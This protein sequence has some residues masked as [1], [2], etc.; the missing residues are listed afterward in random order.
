MNFKDMVMEAMAS[1]AYSTGNTDLSAMAD[2]A[3][4]VFF[5]RLLKPDVIEVMERQ[6]I[7]V[8]ARTDD[9]RECWNSLLPAAI[10]QIKGEWV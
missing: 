10:A 3:I 4:D 6:N 1:E 9:S 2:A 5:T 8:M 7:R